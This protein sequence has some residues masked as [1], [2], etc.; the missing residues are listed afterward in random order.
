MKGFGPWTTRRAR[1]SVP[2]RRSPG[3]RTLLGRRARTREE[4]RTEARGR[5][6]LRGSDE[7]LLGRRSSPYDGTRDAVPRVVSVGFTVSRAPAKGAVL[8]RVSSTF[9]CLSRTSPPCPSRTSPLRL[10]Q[11]RLMPRGSRYVGGL[12]IFAPP[13]W[14]PRRPLTSR[15]GV[16]HVRPAFCLCRDRHFWAPNGT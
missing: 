12:C 7:P 5:R 4:P 14:A 16:R 6:A 3:F 1:A 2:S 11:S 15:R 10:F 8:L 9:P 13:V